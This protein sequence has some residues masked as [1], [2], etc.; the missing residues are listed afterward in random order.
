[1]IGDAGVDAAE[2]AI[3][4]IQLIVVIADVTEDVGVRGVAELRMD[5]EPV[6]LFGAV[7]Y[8]GV[9]RDPAVE[10]KAQA[11]GVGVLVRDHLVVLREGAAWCGSIPP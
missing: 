5:L 7:G 9:A 1:M 3:G 10:G 6:D 2:M 11:R 4:Q 8:D